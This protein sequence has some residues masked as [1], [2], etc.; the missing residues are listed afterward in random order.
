MRFYFLNKQILPSKKIPQ[1]L[2]ITL[3]GIMLSACAVG[4]DLHPTNAPKMSNYTAKEIKQTSSAPVAGGEAQQLVRGKDVSAQWWQAFGSPQIDQ[5]VD[6]AFKH[7]P[8]ID[9]AQAALRQARESSNAQR[10][11]YFPTVQASYSPSR[12]RNAVGTISPTLTSGDPVYT[13]H[14]AQLSISY[15]PDV[16]GMNRRI[17]ESLV[18]QEESQH[19]QLEAT[20]LTLATNVVSNAIQLALLKAQIDANEDIIHTAEKTL[21]LLHGQAQLG[22]SSGL[23][24]A[25]QESA[26]AQ[27][28]LALPPLRKQYEQTQDILAVLTGEFPGQSPAVDITL[29]SLTLPQELPL[30]LPSALVE[31]RP[32]VRASEALVHA[33]SAQVGVAIANRLPQFSLSVNYGGVSTALSHMFSAGNRFWGLA[34]SMT[35]AV[36]DFGTLKHKQGAAEASLDQAT[37]QYRSVV[38]TAFQN[39]ADTLYA[40]DADSQALKAAA[41]AEAAAQKTVDLTRKQFELGAVNITPLLAAKQTYQQTKIVRLQNQAARYTDTAALFQA[42]GGGWWNRK[43]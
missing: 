11:S 24:V 43:N 36:F 40:L 38:L 39:V 14:T 26:L 27:T 19:F 7:N 15:V 42:L 41:N 17:V 31:Q 3:G 34:G 6:A 18:A 1:I 21:D 37:A 13:L 33:A 28:R 29:D 2:V 22:F 30:S 10:G 8:S 4:P 25:A 35:Q 9:I 20:Y 12:Q 16:F 23:D 5:L 32:D